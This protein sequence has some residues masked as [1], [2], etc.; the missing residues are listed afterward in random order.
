MLMLDLWFLMPEMHFLR[1][2]MQLSFDSF[3]V[4]LHKYVVVAW[5][6]RMFDLE[7]GSTSL[8]MLGPSNSQESC[9]II[10]HDQVFFSVPIKTIYEIISYWF[11]DFQVN[12]TFSD[13]FGDK[14]A[15]SICAVTYFRKWHFLGKVN[16]HLLETFQIRVLIFSVTMKAYSWI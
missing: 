11:S 2:I 1:L 8:T 3:S 9:G 16:I 4:F 12:K 10:F 6:V 13:V 15:L 7:I 14:G 5:D